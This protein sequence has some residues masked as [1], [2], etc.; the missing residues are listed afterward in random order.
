M[1]FDLVVLGGGPGGYVAAIRAAQY[2]LKTALIEKD[3]LGGTCL[4]RGCIPTKAMLSTA[5]ILHKMSKASE[6][7]I[8]SDKISVDMPAL[9]ERKNKI[10]NE[11]VT[12]I[13]KIC[14]GRKIT[15][16]NNFGVLSSKKSVKLDSGEE[17]FGKNIILATGS[18]P[19]N[20]PFL[21]IDGENVITSN[22]ALNLN[23]VPENLLVIGGGVVGVEFASMFHEFGSKVTVVEMQKFLVPVEDN[24]VSRTLQTSFKKRGIDLK[25]GV[26]VEKIDVIRDGEIS[27]SFDDGSTNTYSKVLAALGRS[28]NSKGVGFEEVG[29]QLDQK[30]FVQ[31]DDRM[32]TN[33][34]NIY[35]IGDVT[36][37]LLLA[38]TAS[39]QGLA[40]VGDIC[41]KPFRVDYN[42]IPSAV[43]TTP[44][45]ASVG[46]REN[47]LKENKADF[48][49]SR[50]SF[51]AIGKAKAQ[52]EEDGF[53]KIITDS[54]GKKILGA[55][56]IGP[57]A[58]DVLS[59]IT[60]VKAN[61][62]DLD[63]I[64]NTVHSHPT[65]SEAVIEAAEG[66][67]KLAIHSM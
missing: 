36:G 18:E 37:K 27:V 64:I 39:A 38:H 35:A 8:I 33:I 62:F 13:E 32:K 3:K 12:G 54:E 6:F 5:D 57:H 34:D 52:G 43:F 14:K 11:L 58:S 46:E 24:Q 16:F 65:L 7:A 50:F 15:V 4:N 49:V 2:G 21:K 48:K 42:S 56:V 25:L 31:I 9:I 23:N 40:A 44:E 17:I 20:L 61:N 29:I 53:V 10:V 45:I 51:A 47:A 28:I 30:G 41:G 22:E 67:H 60:L 55:H 63:T 26:K 59:E 66:I 1:E 19:L